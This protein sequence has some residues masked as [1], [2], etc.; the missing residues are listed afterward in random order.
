MVQEIVMSKWNHHHANHLLWL[1]ISLCK[2]YNT[3][4][5]VFSWFEPMSSYI[6]PEW[7]WMLDEVGYIEQSVSG[8]KEGYFTVNSIPAIKGDGHWDRE[9]HD[10]L[11]EGYLM[12]PITK[13]LYEN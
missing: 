7:R 4:L 10:K 2:Q 8:E 12:E 1:F 9:A 11:V 6:L 3:R 13:Y 5:F